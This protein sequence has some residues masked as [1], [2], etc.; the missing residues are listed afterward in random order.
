MKDII[1]AKEL[2]KDDKTLILVKDDDVIESTLSGIKPLIGLLNNNKDLN[3]YSIADKIVGKAQ[4][5]LI[6]KANIKE[7]YT[8]V[9]S[10]QG[11]MILKKYNIPYSYETLTDQII[12]RKGTDICPMEKTVKDIDNIEDGY[13][14]LKEAVKNI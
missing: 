4:A 2:L 11:E 14:L 5:M 10:K 12:N 9:L 7:V 13:I 3:G 8:K 1:K 6:V